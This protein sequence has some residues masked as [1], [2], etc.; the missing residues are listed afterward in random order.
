[1]YYFKNKYI[2]DYTVFD[3][4]KNKTVPV[5]SEELFY[6]KDGYDF[7]LGGT[8]ALLR[9]DNPNSS[10]DKELIIFRDSFGS[11]ISPLIAEKYKSENL[12]DIRYVAPF[13]LQNFINPSDKDVL[14][15]Y[16][17]LILNTKSF[18]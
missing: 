6:G 1:M 5:Y 14:F 2:N 11:S 3:Y 17:P 4:E 12:V 9:I 18:K 16:S 15:M 13:S 10:T 7:F 8:K